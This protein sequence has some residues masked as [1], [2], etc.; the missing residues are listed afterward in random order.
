MKAGVDLGGAL[1]A[2]ALPPF[3]NFNMSKVEGVLE[4]VGQVQLQFYTYMG[5]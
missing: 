2:E 1:G 3:Q 4:A 5:N